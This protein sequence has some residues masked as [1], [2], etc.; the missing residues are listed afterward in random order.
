MIDKAKTIIGSWFIDGKKLPEWKKDRMDACLS[1]VYNSKNDGAKKVL[2]RVY[3]NILGAHCLKCGCVI[4]NKT[5]VET[6]QC[7]IGVWLAQK[8]LG[9]S[10]LD[11]DLAEGGVEFGW[12]KLRMRYIANY[13][14]INYNSNSDFKVKIKDE[15]IGNIRI[16]VSCG[17][18]SFDQTGKE[19]TIRYDTA[20]K[21]NI[22]KKDLIIDFMKDKV[23]RQTVI[24]I[25]GLVK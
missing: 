4:D 16:S 13:G 23:K 8:P 1:C 17:C 21:G 6:E 5:S 9:T 3:E 24:E 18:V 10:E 2:N 11:I 12:D 19:I 20:I 25:K 7:P 14:E 15:D 22:N